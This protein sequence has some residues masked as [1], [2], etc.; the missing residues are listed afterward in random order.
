MQLHKKGKHSSSH[1]HVHVCAVLD[2]KIMKTTSMF[3]NMSVKY[4]SNLLKKFK[5]IKYEIIIKLLK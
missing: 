2:K 3:K 1:K 5:I 4:T